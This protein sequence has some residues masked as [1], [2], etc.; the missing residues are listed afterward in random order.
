MQ[1]E[2]EVML[3][4]SYFDWGGCKRTRKKHFFI[5][6]ILVPTLLLRDGV[7]T[8]DSKRQWRGRVYGAAAISFHWLGNGCDGCSRG[9]HLH[10][11]FRD[12]T[13]QQRK[14]SLRDS[15]SEVFPRTRMTK[16]SCAYDCGREPVS[17]GAFPSFFFLLLSPRIVP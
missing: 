17:V 4:E 16:R 2:V 3:V 6:R 10:V 11:G 7:C 12:G 14:V 15:R 9:Y 1:P 8:D 5:F 13:A